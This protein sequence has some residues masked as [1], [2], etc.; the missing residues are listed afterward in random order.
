MIGFAVTGGYITVE[1]SDKDDPTTDERLLGLTVDMAE[2]KQKLN[3]D[4]TRMAEWLASNAARFGFIVRYPKNK[5]S[6]T[7]EAYKPFTLRYVGRYAAIRISGSGLCLEEFA[8]AYNL[9]KYMS[10]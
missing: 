5:E 6:V 7:G 9:S 3:A 2:N 1:G 4:D 8:D 10:Y